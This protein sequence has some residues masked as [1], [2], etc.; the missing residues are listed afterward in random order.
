MGSQFVNSLYQIKSPKVALINVGTE[1][2]KGDSLHKETYYALQEEELNFV[3]NIEARDIFTTDSDVLVTDGFSGNIL[4]K[5]IEG[6]VAV[7][8]DSMKQTFMKNILTKA[9]AL[10]VKSG[11]KEMKTKFDYRELG[12]TPVFGVQGLLLKAH[13]SSDAKA[14]KNAFKSA[15]VMADS[16]FISNLK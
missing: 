11:L 3:G 5:G 14:F 4:L 12:A 8:N 15:D 6:T 13:G 2:G 1:A 9:T 7:F 10:I 16:D